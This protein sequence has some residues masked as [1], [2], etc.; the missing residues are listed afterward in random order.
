M[1]RKRLYQ[2]VD[3]CSMLLEPPPVDPTCPLCSRD[4]D[5]RQGCT[6]CGWLEGGLAHPSRAEALSEPLEP[7]RT[8]SRV[9]PPTLGRSGL[10]GRI[11]TPERRLEAVI[12]GFEALYAVGAVLRSVW[13]FGRRIWRSPASGF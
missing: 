6:A 3:F 5:P 7:D 10:L 9:I 8:V 4:Y 13:V 11:W 2:V 12:L 1:T